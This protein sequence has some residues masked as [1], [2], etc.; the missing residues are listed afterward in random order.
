[1]R[2]AAYSYDVDL[3]NRSFMNCYQR[4]SLVMLAERTPDAHHLLYRCLISTDEILDQIVRRQRPR[5]DFQ[6]RFLDPADLARIGVIREET[7]ADTFAAA[8]DLILDVVAT[9]G[10]ALLVIDVFYL[11]HCPEYRSQHITHTVVVKGHDPATGEWLIIDDNRASVLCEYAYPEDVIAASYDNGVLRRVR[12]FSAK[13]A[14][15]D[16]RRLVVADFAALVARHQDTR[17]L[18]S[19]AGDLLACPWLAPALA[20]S[21]LHQA[22]LA[23]Q[24]SR[25]L[26]REFITQAVG[27]DASQALLGEIAARAGEVH[28]GLLLANVTGTVDR[29]WLSTTC[30]DLADKEERLLHRLRAV[31]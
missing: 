20:A 30:L 8:R 19:G 10:Y 9:R 27:D 26:L 11:P 2:D 16:A 13:E 6:S 1:M 4:Q 25:A 5:Y 23:Y 3:Y 18:L 24:G 22:F 21:L 28:G 15:P 7:P 12:Y 14:D 29:D 31:A 17:V